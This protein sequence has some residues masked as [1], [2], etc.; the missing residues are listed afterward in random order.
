MRTS[1]PAANKCRNFSSG[2][3][4]TLQHA[5]VP[6]V[7]D[8]AKVAQVKADLVQVAVAQ[9]KAD[10]VQVAVA[11]VKADPV[12]VVAALDKADLVP[13]VAVPVVL[14]AKQCELPCSRSSTRTET[15]S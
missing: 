13:A 6:A 7:V 12:Q 10:P 5:Q 9:V 2:N 4:A 14:T 1:V 11:Q 3:R 8:L 15:G